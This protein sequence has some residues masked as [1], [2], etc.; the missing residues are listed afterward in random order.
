M[1]NVPD[2]KA[3]LEDSELLVKLCHEVIERIYKNVEGHEP[4]E[5]EKQL[6]EITRA[7]ERI[8]KAG[9]AIPD[10]LRLEKTR[11]VAS[12]SVSTKANQDFTQLLDGLEEIIKNVKERLYKNHSFNNKKSK[13]HPHSRA[14]KTERTVLRE[15][16]I[17]VLKKLGGSAPGWKVREEIAKLLDGKLLPG[18]LAWRKATKD[19]V[20]QNNT[21]WERYRMTQDGTLKNNSPRGIWE[22]GEDYL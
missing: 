8:E 4:K 20:W 13:K 9:V 22:L 16:I 2:I 5:Y 3:Y 15:L 18:D 12:L 1:S 11:L 6:K 7:I 14:S 19:Y 10:A 17:K 21:N